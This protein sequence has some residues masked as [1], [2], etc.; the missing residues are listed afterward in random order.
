M[1]RHQAGEL[2]I[3]LSTWAG[4]SMLRAKRM[5]P[6]GRACRTKA[7]NSSL[8][9]VP[10]KAQDEPLCAP[11]FARPAWSALQPQD[12]SSRGMLR[13]LD[14]HTAAGLGVDRAARTV[15]A[16]LRCLGEEAVA[17]LLQ[18][19]HVRLDNRPSQ[20]T[21]GADRRHASRGTPPRG[22]LRLD[23]SSSI[24]V[25]SMGRNA[26][27]V[28]SEGTSSRPAGPVPRSTTKRAIA[29]SM[30]GTAMAMWS[31]RHPNHGH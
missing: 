15:R 26:V 27:E 24:F 20:S 9:V 5:N 29:A 6:A 14:Q 23:G 12:A 13:Q 17:L 16:R 28:D 25:P 4:S 31:R 18:P 8:G 30:S 7:A 2:S 19:S 11:A 1:V 21:G 10:L 3:R 22:L